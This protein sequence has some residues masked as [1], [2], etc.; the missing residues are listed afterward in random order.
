MPGRPIPGTVR[1]V[2]LVCSFSLC[3]RD[4]SH[5]DIGGVSG[6][7]GFCGEVRRRLERY[8]ILG[9][10]GCVVTFDNAPKSET[11]LYAAFRA[12][13]VRL[14]DAR[15]DSRANLAICPRIEPESRAACRII[16]CAPR[17][18]LRAVRSSI[19]RTFSA[20]DTVGIGFMM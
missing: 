2:I 14:G 8:R 10:D 12:D 1:A 18:G 9:E 3:A 5:L 15:Y 16:F 17:T 19:A 13:G 11:L 20:K 4:D 7:T 6:Y